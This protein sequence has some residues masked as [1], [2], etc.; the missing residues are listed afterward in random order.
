MEKSLKT[1]NIIKIRKR[2]RNKGRTKKKE[3]MMPRDSASF[4]K[5]L[6]AGIPPSTAEYLFKTK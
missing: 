6:S 2:R 4:F 1:P 5:L 3:E